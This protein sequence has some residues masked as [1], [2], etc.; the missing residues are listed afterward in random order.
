MTEASTHTLDVP[1]ATLHYDVREGTAAAAPTLLMIG[2][3]MDATGFT[4]LAA[5]FPDRTV[6]TV[7]P[8][9]AGRSTRVETGGEST[10]EQHADDLHRVIEALGGGPVDIFASSGGAV[11]ALVLVARHPEQVRL[12]VAHEPPAAQVLPDREPALAAITDVRRAYEQDG[13]GAGMARFMA[14]SGFRGEIPA[15]YTGRPAPD[16]AAFGLPTDDDGSRDD[17]M[18]RQNLVTCTH[19]EHDF[20]ALRAAST[21]IV[22]GVGAESE[23]EM[24]HRSGLAVA[25]RLGTKAVVFPSHHGGFLGGEFGWAGEPDAFAVTLRQTLDEGR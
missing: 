8:R 3:P 24:A 11:N 4:S 15:D 18:F 17:V 6:V 12:L 14:L 10:P 22:V 16:P 1:G 5:H 23:G 25:D 19:H 20:E 2:S 9:G 13:F 7:D 21:R